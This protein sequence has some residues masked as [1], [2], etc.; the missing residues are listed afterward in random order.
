MLLVP[1]EARP[2][3]LHGLGVFTKVPV[4]AGEVVWQFDPGID[5]RHPVSWLES[6]PPHVRAH[7]ATYGVL[8]LDRGS[9]YLGGDHTMFLN[10]SPTPNLVPR[11]E[12]LRNAEG[13]VVAARDIAAGEELTIDYGTIDGGDRDKLAKGLPLFGAR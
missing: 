3:P 1:S 2:S 6:Q 5:H 9:I 12:V 7:V 8:S 10:H 13:V 11:D 4:A